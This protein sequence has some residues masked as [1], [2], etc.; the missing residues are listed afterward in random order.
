M[1]ILL[2]SEGASLI[3]GR[4]FTQAADGR[5]CLGPGS[6]HGVE[7]IGTPV[8]TDTLR[9]GLTI[10]SA[11]NSPLASQQRSLQRLFEN[12]GSR[13]GVWTQLSNHNAVSSP[14]GILRLDGRLLAHKWAGVYRGDHRGPRRDFDL[15]GDLGDMLNRHRIYLEELLYRARDRSTD[16]E[17]R[18]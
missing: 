13:F 2:T 7:T 9:C 8:G 5:K 11:R 18:K 1:S 4:S 15:H 10:G 14:Q 12:T 6:C 17:L 3:R 16:R